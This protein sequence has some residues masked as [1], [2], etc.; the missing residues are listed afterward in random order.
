[1]KFPK[2]IHKILLYLK[3]KKQLPPQFSGQINQLMSRVT[4]MLRFLEEICQINGGL[5]AI[6]STP[7]HIL[8]WDKAFWKITEFLEIVPE[9]SA[10]LLFPFH[11]VIRK[12][13]CCHQ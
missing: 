11:S 12:L 2:E 9:F 8:L 13:P 6:K 3:G 4:R 7:I 10:H 5:L 1:M